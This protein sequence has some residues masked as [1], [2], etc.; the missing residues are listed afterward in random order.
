MRLRT[1][2][3]ISYVLVVLIA[4]FASGALALPL[5]QDYQ[6]KRFEAEVERT[7]RLQAEALDQSLRRILTLDANSATFKEALPSKTNPRVW[8]VDSPTLEA[9]REV[10]VHRPGCWRL[11]SSN[12]TR[13]HS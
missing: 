4:I 9:V 7:R 6:N 3:I 8:P 5:L 2:L 10:F 12:P 1:K 11:Q 13:N